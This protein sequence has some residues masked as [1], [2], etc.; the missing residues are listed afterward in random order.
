MGLTA[1]DKKGRG[2]IWHA[3]SRLEREKSGLSRDASSGSLDSSISSSSC[4]SE[5]SKEKEKRRGMVLEFLRSHV[6]ENM[7]VPVVQSA[8]VLVATVVENKESSGSMDAP[9]VV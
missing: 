5:D 8:N 9:I 4:S 6:G 7:G 1:L 3:Q 2:I